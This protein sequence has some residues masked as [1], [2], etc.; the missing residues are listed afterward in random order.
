M[1]QT[2]WTI[3][4]TGALLCAP[5]L[6]FV[7]SVV[8]AQ[9]LQANLPYRLLDP[10]R[11]LQESLLGQAIL[12]QNREAENA[13]SAENNALAEQLIAEERDL[14]ALRTSLTP[15]EFRAR[16]DAF[17]A[18][19]EEI[20]AERNQRSTALASQAEAAV[21]RFYD[22]ALPVLDQLMT[23]QGVVGLIR[24]EAMILWSERLDITDQ[25]IERLNASFR[26]SLPN[27]DAP[28]SPQQ[29]P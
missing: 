8:M 19:V 2:L 20:R 4:M 14:T 28:V 18:R 3:V 29:Q 15:E 11:L 23:E 26:A 7:P 6:A 1:R 10:D 22:A 12:T 21:Q 9:E 16:A 5:V 27:A 24:P 13:L 25:A 17:D